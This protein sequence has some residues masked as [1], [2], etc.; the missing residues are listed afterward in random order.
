LYI[1]THSLL[2]NFAWS[3]DHLS[4]YAR[5]GVGKI[6]YCEIGD[7]MNE[8]LAIWE[9]FPGQ[10]ATLSYENNFLSRDRGGTH[11]SIVTAVRI[12]DLTGKVGVV[13]RHKVFRADMPVEAE[14]GIGAA[15]HDTEPRAL[16]VTYYAVSAHGIRV[17]FQVVLHC[18]CTCTT[19]LLHYGGCACFG[20]QFLGL[21]G[22][23]RCSRI[24]SA[25]ILHA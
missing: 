7:A 4:G 15:C 12:V 10:C 1:I 14:A 18:P 25:N 22:I 21:A 6:E 3:R 13:K 16:L 8:N 5:N 20:T 11:S 24:L 23:R 19:G 2:I 9:K 17:A